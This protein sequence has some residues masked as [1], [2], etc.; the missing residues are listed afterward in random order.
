MAKSVIDDF[1]SVT[2][3]SN[4]ASTCG[5]I[6]DYQDVLWIRPLALPTKMYQNDI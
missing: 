1:K 3:D 4:D 6:Y 2:D 5:I